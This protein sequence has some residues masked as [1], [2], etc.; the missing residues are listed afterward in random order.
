MKRLYI[1]ALVLVVFAYLP[2]YA[3]IIKIPYDYSTIQGGIDASSNGDTVLVQPGTYRE[4]IEFYRENVVLGSMYLFTEDSSYVL[5]T[6]IDGDS[7]GTV[8]SFLSTI[9]AS[10]VISG[11]T[12]RN[13]Y[14]LIGGGIL[15]EEASPTIR[16]N[17]IT[18]NVAISYGGGIKCSQS[19]PIISNNLIIG[20]HAGIDAGGL[21][22]FMSSPVISNSIISGN[23]AL[24]G[25]GIYGYRADFILSNSVVA[26]NS[27]SWGGGICMD[28]SAPEISNCTFQGN[29]ADTLG[30]GLLSWSNH[31]TPEITNCIFWNDSAAV[32][33]E[34]NVIG[35][36]G[37]VSI[38]C[39][40]E[41]GWEGEGNIDCDP[42]FCDSDNDNFYLAENSCCAGAGENGE[43]I[44]ALGIGCEL[45]RITDE[46]DIVPSEFN[47]EQNYPNPFNAA[48]VINYTLPQSGAVSIAIYNLLGQRIAT[49]FEDEKQAGRHTINWDAAAFPSGVYFARLDAGDY[50]KSIKM[51]LLK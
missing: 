10:T 23:S 19:N 5:S 8:V 28:D 1:F 18:D 32:G 9:T 17:I 41:G 38:Y 40:V 49:L 11:F 4:N 15:C 39:D 43:D 47:I 26:A 2:V 24:W 6:I 20:N 16:D 48:T 34:I 46:E 35:S 30:G 51:V 37:A 7:R 31:G 36:S 29:I 13:G 33:D 50:S 42:L 12:I 22:L 25:G 3:T 44:G 21:D 45:T 27:A 14:A